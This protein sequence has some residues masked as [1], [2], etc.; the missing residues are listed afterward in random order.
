VSVD[1]RCDMEL[2]TR[3]NNV[4]VINKEGNNILLTQEMVSY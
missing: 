1:N 4:E 2:V 3:A